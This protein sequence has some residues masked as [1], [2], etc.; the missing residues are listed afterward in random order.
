MLLTDRNFNTSFYE[1]AGGGDPVLYQHLFWFFGHPEVYILVIPGFGMVSHIISEFSGKPVFGKL[2]MVY[3]MLSIGVLGCIVWSQL[4]AFFL[5]KK[6][7]IN[8]TIGWKSS[9]HVNTFDSTNVTCYTQSAGNFKII[10]KGS[11]ETIRGNSFNIFRKAYNIIYKKDIDILWLSWFIGFVEGDGAILEYNK[12]S[13]LVI[14]QKDPTVL[15]EIQEKLGFGRIKHF[16]D[17]TGNTK[18]SRYFVTDN[19]SILLLYLL[20]NG[21]LV[22]KQR[23]NQLNKWYV[24]LKNAPKLDL[25]IYKLGEL[26]QVTQEL[27]QPTLKD[28]WLSGFTDAEGCFT[29]S[30]NYQKNIAHCR[31][32][33]DQKNGMESLQQIVNL[34][35]HGH[36]SLRKK[37]EHVYRL[38]LHMNNPNRLGY[39]LILDY[40]DTYCLKTSKVKNYLLW[41]EI[42]HEIKLQTH[43]TK[44]GINRIEKIKKLMTKYIIENNPIGSSKYS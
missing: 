10:E 19:N 13:R 4:M 12:Q 40:F 21:N 36:V 17:K 2:G 18:Y 3:A 35:S 33:L 37:T 9:T 15:L 16:I 34:C 11:P 26:S 7:V 39:N 20:F 24:A 27:Y 28:G 8:S 44:E 29:T 5:P 14:T 42:L 22:L 31:F 41:K 1:A 43:K 6:K 23:V 25:S 32:I 38:T 30:I